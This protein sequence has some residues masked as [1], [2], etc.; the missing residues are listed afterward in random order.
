MLKH[1]IQNNATT[2]SNLFLKLEQK[3]KQKLEQVKS[4]AVFQQQY[5]LSKYKLRHYFVY[6]GLHGENQVVT[7][8]YISYT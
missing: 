4:I 8:F 6:F 1:N 2:H 7:I 3:L 5:I